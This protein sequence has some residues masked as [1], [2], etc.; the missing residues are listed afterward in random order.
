[1]NW[2]SQKYS[3]PSQAVQSNN[4]DGLIVLGVF[5]KVGKNNAEFDKLVNSLTKVALNGKSAEFDDPI[6]YRGLF[7]SKRNT[8]F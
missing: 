8:F 2:N 7:P 3:E 4:H 1:V 6:D 5:V